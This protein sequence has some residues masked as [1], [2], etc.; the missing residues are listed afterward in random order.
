VLLYVG[1]FFYAQSWLAKQKHLDIN[2]LINPREKTGELM[3]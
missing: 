3:M 1:M 2:H